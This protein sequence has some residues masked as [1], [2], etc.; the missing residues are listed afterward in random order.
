[1]LECFGARQQFNRRQIFCKIGN[2]AEFQR[3]GHSHRNVVFFSTRRG[4]IVD[5]GWMGED[6]CFVE[7]S[8]C[9]DMRNHEAGFH[10]RTP[11]KERGQTFVHIGIDQPFNPA[12]ANAHQIR[13][14]DGSIIK[15]QRK[16]RAVKIAAGNN[17]AVLRKNQWVISSRTRFD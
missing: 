16:R 9:S 13:H 6:S 2:R 14:C 8:G 17:I 15:C 3:A 12:L 5:A 11:G 10:A 7:Q 1:M 4:N